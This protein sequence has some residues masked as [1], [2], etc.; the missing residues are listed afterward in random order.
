MNER[1]AEHVILLNICCCGQIRT[2]VSPSS[3]A[4]ETEGPRLSLDCHSNLLGQGASRGLLCVGHHHV[5][6]SSRTG[7]HIVFWWL[8]IFVFAVMVFCREAVGLVHLGFS[9][10]A[11]LF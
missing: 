9:P 5:G 4:N 1:A 3:Q 10:E 6:N 8:R 2:S 7:L 11:L